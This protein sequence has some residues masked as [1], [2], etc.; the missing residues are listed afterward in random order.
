MNVESKFLK[1]ISYYD[2]ISCK[3][4]QIA[5]ISDWD[6]ILTINGVDCCF[7]LSAKPS[8]VE[9]Y[10]EAYRNNSNNAKAYVYLDTADVFLHDNP[11]IPHESLFHDFLIDKKNNVL[12]VG[13]PVRNKSVHE[14]FFNILK[15]EENRRFD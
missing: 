7:I 9:R 12:L 5:H 8:E 4:C 15:K 13:N 10:M 11:R 3:P 6:E 14:L 2:T 1:W